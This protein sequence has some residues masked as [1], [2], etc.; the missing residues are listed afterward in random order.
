MQTPL[1]A[2][3]NLTF[4]YEAQ[5]VLEEITLKVEER[6]FLAIIGPN[7][8]GKST[9]LKL[10]LGLL[11]PQQ[12]N[13][14]LLGHPPKE[15]QHHIGYVPQNTNI[16][17]DFPIKVIEVV[18]IGHI[19]GSKPLFGYGKDEIACAM[20]ALAQVGMEQFADE[21]IGALS[22][23]QRQRVMIARALCAH[24]KILIL[25]EPTASIDPAGQ[26]EIYTLLE[27]LNQQMTI[28]VVSHD[29]SVILKYAN[30]VAFINRTLVWH[31]ITDK[32]QIFHTHTD[33]EHLCEIELLQML[34]NEKCNSCLPDE[35]EDPITW[36]EEK[37]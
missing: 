25:D 31:D 28:I 32:S 19:G 15:S 2:I 9:L 23:G 10:I 18:L 16:N 13:I 20:G 5:P 4:A 14:S 6:D 36:Q 7:G 33:T 27:M 24:P 17:I 29:L 1:I 3:E 35:A 34:G 8:G 11:S 30:K 21:K 22:G 37:R 12:G 26:K